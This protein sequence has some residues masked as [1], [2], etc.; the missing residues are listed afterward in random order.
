MAALCANAENNVRSYV[1]LSPNCGD[2]LFVSFIR[3]IS[4][5]ML[6]RG[7]LIPAVFPDWR[8]AV[9]VGVVIGVLHEVA[10]QNN[11]FV[12]WESFVYS[13]DTDDQSCDTD[14]G[15]C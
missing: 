12:I 15:I 13:E 7:G 14:I 9:I 4:E 3:G 2:I 10:G 8:G 1:L 11:A 5:E 6:F